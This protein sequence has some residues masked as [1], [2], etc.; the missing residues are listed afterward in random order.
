MGEGTDA[1]ISLPK[2]GGAVSGLGE[3]FSADLF[4]GAAHFTV[5]IAVPAG[6][7][8]LTP[9]LSLAY[10]TGT[11]NGPFGMGW[12]LSLPGVS[13]RTARGIPRYVDDTWSIGQK[14]TWL[15]SKGLLGAMIWE[16]SGDT[17]TLM[18]AV[19]SGLR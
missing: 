10:S 3:K 14:M 13:R 2:G 18:S 8:G 19:D 11:G 6:R 12:Q 7:S 16:M 5:P 17:G 4:T 1:V 15:K 9:E